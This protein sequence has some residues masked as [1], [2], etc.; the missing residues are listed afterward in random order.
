[1]NVQL[2]IES[3]MYFVFSSLNTSPSFGNESRVPPTNDRLHAFTDYSSRPRRGSYKRSLTIATPVGTPCDSGPPQPA[4]LKPKDPVVLPCR[5]HR[6]SKSFK[7]IKSGDKTWSANLSSQLYNRRKNRTMSRIQ[8]IGQV[9]KPTPISEENSPQ[10]KAHDLSPIST[11]A[12]VRFSIGDTTRSNTL[13]EEYYPKN[14]GLAPSAHHNNVTHFPL[15]MPS[16]APIFNRQSNSDGPILKASHYHFPSVERASSQPIAISN[17]SGTLQHLQHLQHLRGTMYPR[18]LTEG[19]E[20]NT[21]PAKQSTTYKPLHLPTIPTTLSVTPIVTPSRTD[22][23]SITDDIDTSGVKYGGSPGSPITPRHIYFG[24]DVNVD[25][26]TQKENSNSNHLGTRGRPSRADHLKHAEEAEHEQMELTIRKRIRQI[27]LTESDSLYNIARQ[28]IDTLETSDDNSADDNYNGYFSD[29]Q[30]WLSHS[31]VESELHLLN[32]VN[33]E[34][35]LDKLGHTMDTYMSTE[36]RNLK[37]QSV[38]P[39][40]K[41]PTD[42]GFNWPTTEETEETGELPTT[43]C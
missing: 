1:M 31:C 8:S 15:S 20:P 38:S 12:R 36:L 40:N 11:S 18:T 10:M 26:Y 32:K 37:S 24:L 39:P 30:E 4:P 34:P 25:L 43:V 42:G 22:Y 19:H 16:T 13:P 29:E 41:V 28:A 27:S 14:E 6:K 23:T 2:D 3:D 17:N 5:G 21:Q 7:V 9:K 35:T 33:S